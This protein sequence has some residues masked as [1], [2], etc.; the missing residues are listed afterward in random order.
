VRP[1]LLVAVRG[2]VVGLQPTADALAGDG[3]AV[4]IVLGDLATKLDAVAR[5]GADRLDVRGS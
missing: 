3:P 5:I 4:P 2:T 1:G